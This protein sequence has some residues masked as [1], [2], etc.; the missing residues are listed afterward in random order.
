MPGTKKKSSTSVPV[1]ENT[2]ANDKKANNSSELSTLVANN[3]LA[4]LINEKFNTVSSNLENLSAK[5]DLIHTELR[6]G[7]KQVENTALNALELA[8]T[9]AAKLQSLESR[10]GEHE[11]MFSD[12][13]ETISTQTTE[14][15]ELKQSVSGLATL[16]NEVTDLIEKNEKLK[17][18]VDELSTELDDQVN[19]SLRTTLRFRGIP[20]TPNEKWTD[21]TNKLIESIQNICPTFT[22]SYLQDNIER[23]HRS[24]GDGDNRTIIAK[25][26]SW[27]A[28]KAV[29][30]HI[31]E[32][33]KD[34]QPSIFVTPM[35]SHALSKRI[36]KALKHRKNLKETD[37]SFMMY[38]AYP[39]KLMR[40]KRDSDDKY[41]L[42]KE[43]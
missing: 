39:A 13:N 29:K 20:E 37:D 19:R 7:L 2:S 31:I 16:E 28:S 35:F 27:K 43:F 26:S 32:Y 11:T 10:L 23:A 9:N 12:V 24:S 3:N 18:K 8:N 4:D 38:V 5:M 34:N 36:N 22:T 25:F 40:K 6:K 14:T 42:L 33:N 17:T 30:K 41:E 15:N 21:T 1:E